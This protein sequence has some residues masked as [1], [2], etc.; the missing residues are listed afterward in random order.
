MIE[1]RGS[2]T[3]IDRAYGRPAAHVARHA[4][5]V[6]GPPREYYV[7]GLRD[8]PEP[9]SWRTEVCWPVFHTGSTR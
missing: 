6:D 2:P 8:N 1:H 4:L 9:A 3:E 5:A 7:V